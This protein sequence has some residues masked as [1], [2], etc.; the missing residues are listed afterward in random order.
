MF[1]IYV[2]ILQFFDMLEPK[3]NT[4]FIPQSACVMYNSNKT[5]DNDKPDGIMLIKSP[6]IY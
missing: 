3:D 2:K 4:F 6:K 5:I 1:R